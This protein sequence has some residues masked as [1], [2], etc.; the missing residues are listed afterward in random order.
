MQY[1]QFYQSICLDAK[2]RRGGGTTLA[3][4][5]FPEAC[6]RNAMGVNGN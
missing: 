6:P 1:H 5:A 4:L 2:P 3:I